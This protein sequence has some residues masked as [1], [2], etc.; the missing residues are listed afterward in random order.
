[1]V[2][3]DALRQE[4]GDTHQ[5][6]KTVMRWTGASERTIKN[7]LAGRSGPRGEHLVAL[8]R[9]SDAVFEV[10]LRAAGSEPV[11]TAAKLIDSREALVEM[12]DA[13][14]SLLERT[15][16]TPEPTQCGD[17]TPSK[18]TMATCRAEVQVRARSNA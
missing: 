2:V 1:M 11:V 4:L 17:C 5:A 12:R 6:I 13:I 15:G 18:N 14:N 7:W 8:V 10:F 3:A 16:P 9:H